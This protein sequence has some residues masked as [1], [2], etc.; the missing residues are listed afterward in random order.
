MSEAGAP[1]EDGGADAVRLLQH[2]ERLLDDESLHRRIATAAHHAA[3]GR[4]TDRIAA[5]LAGDLAGAAHAD[6]IAA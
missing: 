6:L 5:R 4:A 1:A 2:A 3:D